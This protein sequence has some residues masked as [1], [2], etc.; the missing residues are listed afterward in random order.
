[1]RELLTATAIAAGLL[2]WIGALVC[3]A[4]FIFG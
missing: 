2:T 4:A 1:M 3:A